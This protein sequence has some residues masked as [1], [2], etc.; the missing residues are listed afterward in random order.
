MIKLPT[1]LLIIPF[2]FLYPLGVTAANL[3]VCPSGCG[4]ASI[5]EA[6][7]Y[8]LPGDI[9]RVAEGT[10]HEAISIIGKSD[11]TINGSYSDNLFSGRDYSV[12]PSI[13]DSQGVGNTIL[14]SNSINIAVDG[15]VI[16]NGQAVDGA[17]VKIFSDGANANTIAALSNSVI[18]ENIATY[19][20]GVAI[21]ADNLGHCTFT[22]DNIDSVIGCVIL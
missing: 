14:V 9:V 4:Y 1:I 18:T 11:L 19:G 21:V 10:Y 5:Q 2:L 6:I 22:M 13:I 7:D 15:F 3:D 17:G 8:S 20:G 12:T 16:K